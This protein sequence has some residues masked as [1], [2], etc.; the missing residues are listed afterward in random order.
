MTTPVVVDASAGVEIALHTARGKTLARLLPAD[1]AT[2]APEH[3]FAE[4]SSAMRRL[5][6]VERRIDARTAAVALDEAARLVRRRVNV[7]RLLE[8]AWA[9]RFNITTGDALYVV[10]AKHLRCS[11]LTGD[12]RLAGAPKL[13]VNVLY[14]AAT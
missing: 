3:Y 11:L 8:E 5:E 2:W 10:V 7:R 6:V 4:V 14:L 12:R 13:P 1:A 9:H